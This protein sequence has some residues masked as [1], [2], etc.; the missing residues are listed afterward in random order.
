MT[1]DE[2]IEELKMYPGDAIV[3][4][5]VDRYSIEC[6]DVIYNKNAII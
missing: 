3:E 6:R 2:L 4:L 1:V 5:H